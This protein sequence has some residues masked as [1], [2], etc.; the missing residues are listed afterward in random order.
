[1][2]E[3]RSLTQS[4]KIC[5][6]LLFYARYVYHYYVEYNSLNTI[7][8]DLFDKSNKHDLNDC[9]PKSSGLA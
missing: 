1:M 3:M 5:F 6:S 4:L 9:D 2:C 7:H 8:Y